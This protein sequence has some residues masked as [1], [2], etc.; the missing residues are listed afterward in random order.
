MSAAKNAI[1]VI[2][3]VVRTDATR[4]KPLSSRR[5]GNNAKRTGGVS[6]PDKKAHQGFHRKKQQVPKWFLLGDPVVK[7]KLFLSSVEKTHAYSTSKLQ[8][9]LHQPAT[10]EILWPLYW[11]DSSASASTSFHHK[12]LSLN[13]GWVRGLTTV[14]LE[15]PC[16]P[17]PLQLQVLHQIFRLPLSLRR[18]GTPTL[19]G[20]S[21][22]AIHKLEQIRRSTPAA[23]TQGQG[24]YRQLGPQHQWKNRGWKNMPLS[25]PFL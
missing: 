16:S 14:K 1:L 3:Q 7:S 25:W 12:I 13:T 6:K 9:P 21:P 4:N 19:D 11:A 18:K 5:Q 15:V 10:A 2:A 24:S 22:A 17:A 23:L 20:K 8:T